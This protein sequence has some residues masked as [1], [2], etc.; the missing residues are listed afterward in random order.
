MSDRAVCFAG[1]ASKTIEVKISGQY[2]L[3]DLTL[4]GLTVTVFELRSC[5][6]CSRRLVPYH[7]TRHCGTCDERYVGP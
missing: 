6:R 3:H 1:L 5:S 7:F 4:V 2:K